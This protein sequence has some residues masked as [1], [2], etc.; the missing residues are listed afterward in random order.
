MIGTTAETSMTCADLDPMSLGEAL[1]TFAVYGTATE[2]R[3][4]RRILR[5]IDALANRDEERR[6]AERELEDPERFQPY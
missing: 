4:A 5:D 2:Q 6:R 3:A 1:S